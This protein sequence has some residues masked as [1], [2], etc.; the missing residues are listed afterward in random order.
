MTTAAELAKELRALYPFD[1]INSPTTQAADLLDR[2]AR[3][4]AVAEA[5][6]KVAAYMG[7][8]EPDELEPW[9]EFYSALRALEEK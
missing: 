4:E 2:M 6:M 1:G 3:L 9:P 5:A 7:E 8:E